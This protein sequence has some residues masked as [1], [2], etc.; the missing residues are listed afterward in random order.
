MNNNLPSVGSVVHMMTDDG[1]DYGDVKI[2]AYGEHGQ[3]TAVLVAKVSPTGSVQGMHGL[4]TW[5]CKF[6]PSTDTLVDELCQ[7]INLYYGNPKGSAQ[8][9]GLAKALFA[10]GYRK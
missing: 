8:Y 6:L 7:D 3:D 1:T 9:L 4:I 2:L 10:Q 5:F